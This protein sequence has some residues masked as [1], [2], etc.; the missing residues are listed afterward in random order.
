M[1]EPPDPWNNPSRH[2]T[3]DEQDAYKNI[4]TLDKNIDGI[5]ATAFKSPRREF[6]FR[7][8]RTRCLGLICASRV[9]A[10]YVRRQLG[11]QQKCYRASRDVTTGRVC[12]TAHGSRMRACLPTEN[13]TGYDAHT[14]GDTVCPACRG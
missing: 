2:K 1:N 12:T 10:A 9:I 11:R 5:T 4:I 13:V 3:L 6:V 7:V 8:R 14:R